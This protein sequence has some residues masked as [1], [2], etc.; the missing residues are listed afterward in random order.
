MTARR[1]RALER[2]LTTFGAAEALCTKIGLYWLS[3]GMPPGKEAA[4]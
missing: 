2:A 3:C 1:M 4:G